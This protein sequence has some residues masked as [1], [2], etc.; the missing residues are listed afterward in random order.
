MKLNFALLVSLESTG[1]GQCFPQHFRACFS[2]IYQELHLGDTRVRSGKLESVD[3]LMLSVPCG[4][5][6]RSLHPPMSL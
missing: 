1:K 5:A 3:I 6:V 4:E 2:W